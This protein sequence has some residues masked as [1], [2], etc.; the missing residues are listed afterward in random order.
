[1]HHR[2][3]HPGREGAV[4]SSPPD[5]HRCV[6]SK[7]RRC[8][9]HARDVHSCSAASAW[10]LTAEAFPDAPLA[11]ASMLVQA[12]KH[13]HASMP[14]DRCAPPLS[15][16]C[17]C[18]C[19]C[20]CVCACARGCAA[21]AGLGYTAGEMLRMS[22]VSLAHCF[23]APTLVLSLSLLFRLPPPQSRNPKP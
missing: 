17:A 18:S 3:S 12:C 16:L 21:L 6:S 10:Q 4:G 7:P 2:S 11:N 13:D 15:C 9:S 20:A 23:P 1:M 19:S 5:A 14:H 8:L 22:K